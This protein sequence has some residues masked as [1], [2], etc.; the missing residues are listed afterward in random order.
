[1]IEDVLR[2]TAVGLA[3][4]AAVLVSSNGGTKRTGIGVGLFA[5]SA[6]LWVAVGFMADEY[7]LVAQNVFLV[8]INGWGVWQYFYRDQER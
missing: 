4:I 5:V 2:W 6:A 3:I 8:A 7:N 1:M